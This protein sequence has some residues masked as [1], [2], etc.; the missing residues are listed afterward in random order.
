M[1]SGGDGSG[2]HFFIDV[3]TENSLFTKAA[4]ENISVADG[5]DG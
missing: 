1:K 3:A 5:D 4:M 2:R